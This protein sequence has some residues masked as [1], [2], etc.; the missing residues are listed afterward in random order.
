MA[1]EIQ[2]LAERALENEED[3]A[4]DA[5]VGALLGSA[6][7]LAGIAGKLSEMDDGEERCQHEYKVRG[8]PLNLEAAAMD[9]I[10]C[11]HQ[12][13][14]VEH[15]GEGLVDQQADDGAAGGDG[16]SGEVAEANESK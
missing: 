14:R 7:P 9:E 13:Q 1:D 8:D 16:E 2:L 10:R 3:G 15:E 4:V 12:N 5:H 11:Q 6:D